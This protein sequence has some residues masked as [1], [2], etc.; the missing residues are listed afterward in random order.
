[1]VMDLSTTTSRYR[2]YA[3]TIE[4]ELA[5]HE[6]DD[7]RASD[8]APVDVRLSVDRTPQAA[9]PSRWVH[10]WIGANGNRWL[11]FA[12][13]DGGYLLRFH[14]LT[15]F[16]IDAIGARVV[17][18]ASATPHETLS[19]L[20]LDHVLPLVL[21]VRGRDAL[22]ATAVLAPRGVCAFLGETG[23][24]KSTLA[25]SFVGAGLPLVCDDCLPIAESG[26]AI[27]AY[28]GYAGLRLCDDAVAALAPAHA[29]AP[30]VAHYTTKRRVLFGAYAGEGPHALA[31]VYVVTRDEAAASP[32][33][34]PLR[35]QDAFRALM[36]SSFRLDVE[37]RAMLERQL[38]L[39][40]ALGARDLVRRLRVPND[41]GSIEMT[42]EL[43]EADVAFRHA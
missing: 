12:R 34:E 29:S 39:F 1:M 19:H 30:H 40:A 24:G 9:S 6:L 23:S 41:L 28:G 10:D 31:R 7:A 20:V 11:S 32:R 33:I 2:V 43:V 25:A 27:V 14:G 5:L 35:G 8:A 36:E 37:D 17:V 42:R 16:H 21:N 4:S 3:M 26:G 38:A 18:D 15:D 13:E 22:H